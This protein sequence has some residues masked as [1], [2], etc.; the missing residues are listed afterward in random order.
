ME[1]R[2]KSTYTFDLFLVYIAAPTLGID[3]P[4][5][6]APHSAFFHKKSFSGASEPYTGQVVSFVFEEGPKGAAATKVQEEEGGVAV[7]GDSV[8]D[9]AQREMGTVK[10]YLNAK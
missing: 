10:V 9:E 8:E 4:K 6:T 3:R 2:S 1:K 7:D 5:L